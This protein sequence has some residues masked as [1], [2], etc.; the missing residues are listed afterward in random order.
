MHL[1]TLSWNSI[2][3]FPEAGRVAEFGLN[4]KRPPVPIPVFKLLS[5]SRARAAK[6]SAAKNFWFC[7]SQI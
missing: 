5:K 1:R 7:E 3:G 6:N 4:W 2:A